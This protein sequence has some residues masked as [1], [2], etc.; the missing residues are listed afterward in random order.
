MV[1]GR[2]W[3]SG[4]ADRGHYSQMRSLLSNVR[5]LDGSQPTLVWNRGRRV[6]QLLD[7]LRECGLD[8]GEDGK[9]RATW[10]AFGYVLTRHRARYI[11]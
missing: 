8:P 6:E 11:R 5:C 7:R 4:P 10:L 1:P 9:G 2:R 3:G